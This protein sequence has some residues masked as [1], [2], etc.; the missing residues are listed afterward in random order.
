MK[1][2]SDASLVGPW[3][4][5]SL[6]SSTSAQFPPTKTKCQIPTTQSLA[7]LNNNH[8]GGPLPP[9]PPP[10]PLDSAKESVPFTNG[11]PKYRGA[12]VPVPDS[13]RRL[14]REPGYSFQLPVY[15]VSPFEMRFLPAECM[16]PM[17]SNAH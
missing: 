14:Y 3:S 17:A 11:G 2:P 5:M 1:R 10:A 13:R 8:L 15:G 16:C 12:S 6:S 9:A 7:V 4:P